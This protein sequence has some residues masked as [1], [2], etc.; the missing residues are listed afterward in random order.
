MQKYFKFSLKKK[1]SNNFRIV[2]AIC[3]K[4][5]FSIFFI[6]F[7][8]YLVKTHF[9]SYNKTTQNKRIPN[10]VLKPLTQNFFD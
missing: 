7:R 8:F 5:Y 3:K 2:L 1:S 6:I 10:R 9:F 4:K